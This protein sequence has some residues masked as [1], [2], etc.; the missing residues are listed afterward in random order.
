[1]GNL[2]VWFVDLEVVVK[3]YVD[4]DDTIVVGLSLEKL[5][6]AVFPRLGSLPHLLL[7]VL[8]GIEDFAW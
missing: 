6:V 4:V 7:N 2:K 3:E 5:A 8:C 1:M